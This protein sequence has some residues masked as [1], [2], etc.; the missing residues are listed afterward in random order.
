MPICMWVMYEILCSYL[1]MVLPFLS[2]DVSFFFVLL[3][4]VGLRF[5]CGLLAFVASQCR[6]VDARVTRTRKSFWCP[7]LAVDIEN[8]DCFSKRCFPKTAK[9]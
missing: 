2:G 8:L 7:L 1:S 4:I 6:G 3:L 5:K 9:R